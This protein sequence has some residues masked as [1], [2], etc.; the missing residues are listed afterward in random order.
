MTRD[1]RMLFVL[2]VA[3]V[4]TVTTKDVGKVVCRIEEYKWFDH[5]HFKLGCGHGLCDPVSRMGSHVFKRSTP[6]CQSCCTEDYCNRNCT[7]SSQGQTG[8]VIVG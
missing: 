5:S 8:S 3:M 2:N 7:T 6:V 1:I 4:I